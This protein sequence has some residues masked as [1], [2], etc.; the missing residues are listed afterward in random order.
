MGHAPAPRNLEPH[1]DFLVAAYETDYNLGQ[2]AVSYV[3]RYYYDGPGGFRKAPE[4]VAGQ[5]LWLLGMLARDDYATAEQADEL[6]VAPALLLLR[7]EERMGV[8]RRYRPRLLSAVRLGI[9]EGLVP[10][11]PSTERRPA[12]LFP[13]DLA[14]FDLLSRNM[15]EKE[16]ARLLGG[17]NTGISGRYLPRL[18]HTLGVEH[19]RRGRAVLRMYELGIFQRGFAYVSKLAEYPQAVRTFDELLGRDRPFMYSDGP[20]T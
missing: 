16:T 6:E 11:T 7:L 17:S 2:L 8:G 18:L 9:E 10:F 14:M 5:E 4:V 19:S 3:L 15:T 13:Y 20:G 1:G 12:P